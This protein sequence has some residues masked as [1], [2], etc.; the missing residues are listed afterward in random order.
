MALL[1][2]SMVLFQIFLAARSQ[3]PAEIRSIISIYLVIKRFVKRFRIWLICNISFFSPKCSALLFLVM[4]LMSCRAFHSQLIKKL[5]SCCPS[6]SALT[7]VIF[8]REPEKLFCPF[9]TGVAFNNYISFPSD[10]DMKEGWC[11][12]LSGMW[13]H[14][15]GSV[16]RAHYLLQEEYQTFTV[17][18]LVVMVWFYNSNF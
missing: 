11:S 13:K 2:P 10:M 4:F 16:L 1:S 8:S 5:S 3:D 7:F 15:V 12:R 6:Y 17:R 18:K 14:F 9:N